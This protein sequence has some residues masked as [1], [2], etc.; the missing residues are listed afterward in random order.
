MEVYSPVFSLILSFFSTLIEPVKMAARE[1]LFMACF[2]IPQH[3]QTYDV[4]RGIEYIEA[5]ERLQNDQKD[6]LARSLHTTI[7]TLVY[8]SFS[9]P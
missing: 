7:T 9:P 5:E 4:H 2:S 6:C 3:K 8:L 1:A